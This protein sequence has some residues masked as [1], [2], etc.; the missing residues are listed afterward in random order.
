VQVVWEGGWS[1]VKLLIVAQSLGTA[2]IPPS[3]RA[4]Q[5]SSSLRNLARYAGLD[6]IEE[7]YRKA[8]VINL[9]PFY[10]KHRWPT[11]WAELKARAMLHDALRDSTLDEPVRVIGLGGLVRRAIRGTVTTSDDWFQWHRW[12]KVQ[13][14]F[15]PHPSG[16][17]RAWNDDRLRAQGL[18]FWHEAMG[19]PVDALP[20]D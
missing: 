12:F 8:D 2:S 7:V 1:A 3:G 11:E 14:A 15:S 19:V 4:L 18:Q 13:V 5:G 20:F 9:V 6:D 10:V 16:L 17:S